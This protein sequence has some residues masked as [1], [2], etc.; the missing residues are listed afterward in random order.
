MALFPNSLE[1]TTIYSEEVWNT[2]AKL[3][4]K[5]RVGHTTQRKMCCGN[6][7]PNTKKKIA[8]AWARLASHQDTYQNYSGKV[9]GTTAI[10]DALARLYT[11]MQYE[12]EL[13]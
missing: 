9:W 2:A 3:N 7:A 1:S 4:T 10:L 8:K 12:G 5:T 13:W 11:I 6:W